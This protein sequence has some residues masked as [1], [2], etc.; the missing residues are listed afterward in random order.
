MTRLHSAA[1]FFVNGLALA[2][3]DRIFRSSFHRVSVTSTV[4]VAG[5]VSFFS[6]SLFIALKLERSQLRGP[7]AWPDHGKRRPFGSGEAGEAR[8]RSS[9]KR[10]GWESGGAIN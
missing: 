5:G 6:L 1:F 8:T 3:R 10:V 4:L 9:G 2:S 7:G